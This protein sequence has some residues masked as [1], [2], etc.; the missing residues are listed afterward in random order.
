MQSELLP[1]PQT[2]LALQKRVFLLGSGPTLTLFAPLSQPLLA[3]FFPEVA[4]LPNCGI[5]ARCSRL[6]LSCKHEYDDSCK[7]GYLRAL[8]L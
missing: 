1:V 5:T 3:R 8:Y 2:F 6:N 4:L 7:N